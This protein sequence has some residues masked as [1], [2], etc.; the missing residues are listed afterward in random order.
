MYGWMLRFKGEEKWADASHAWGEHMGEGM[1]NLC[2]G[3]QVTT[4]IIHGETIHYDAGSIM[5]FEFLEH[6]DPQPEERR[7]AVMFNP[8]EVKRFD[9]TYT[10]PGG[11]EYVRA[12]DYDSLLALFREVVCFRCKKADDID[13]MGM[14]IKH[15]LMA[16]PTE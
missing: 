9:H 14:C 8:C 4:K 13:A 16:Y 12:E 10:F 3:R 11:G 15:K 6:R 7:T 5:G 1:P 2:G